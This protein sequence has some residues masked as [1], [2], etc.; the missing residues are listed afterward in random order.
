MADSIEVWRASMPLLSQ[1]EAFALTPDDACVGSGKVPPAGVYLARLSPGSRRAQAAAL[2]TIA[3]LLSGG[4]AQVCPWHHLTYQHGQAIRAA[5]AASYAPATAN[6]MLAAL[7]G[8]LIEAWRLGLMDTDAYRRA[9]DIRSI[10][11][12]SLPRGRALTSGELL[13]LFRTCSLGPERSGPRDAA[14]L[15]SLYAGGIR[16][17]EAIDLDLD[18]YNRATGCLT[19]RAGKGGKARLVYL[20]DGARNAMDDWVAA[21]GPFLGP[22]FVRIRR[23]GV[24][25]YTRLSPQAVLDILRRRCR[26]AGVRQASPHDLRRSMISDLLDAGADIVSVQ[27]LAGHAS[28]TTTARYDRR[29]EQAKQ[30][31]AALLHV[32]YQRHSD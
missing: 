30:R 19:V 28:V 24:L 16:R 17:S 31:T 25:A 11:G 7:R 13:A 21:R 8:V 23:G 10:P 20:S 4:P 1:S 9:C 32:P 5:L 12:T 22:L 15:G 2:E 26:E 3:H 18:D 27:K 14:L 29:G 6:R